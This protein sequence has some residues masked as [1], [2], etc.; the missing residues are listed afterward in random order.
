MEIAEKT[1]A[2]EFAEFEAKNGPSFA[3]GH[4]IAPWDGCFHL[5]AICFIKDEYAYVAADLNQSSRYKYYVKKSPLCTNKYL[6]AGCVLAD[7]IEFVLSE[8]KYNSGI[9]FHTIDE[10]CENTPYAMYGAVISMAKKL[11]YDVSG[12]FKCACCGTDFADG[13][14]CHYL[15]G[16]FKGNGGIGI[17]VGAPVCEECYSERYC[18]YCGAEVDPEL[19][20]AFGEEQE[21]CQYCAEEV[22]CACGEEVKPGNEWDLDRVDVDAYNAGQCR[23]CYIQE[24]LGEAM[25]AD[26]A[27]VENETGSLFD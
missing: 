18:G 16:E 22:V 7:Q 6:K 23:E 19:N 2:Q 17:E 20:S 4:V 26:Y 8:P 5:N 12:Q 9:E 11:G 25:N 1:V 24:A 13:Y 21:H 27:K 14:D 10:L 3:Y 15:E